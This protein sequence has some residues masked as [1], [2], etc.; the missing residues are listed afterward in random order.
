MSTGSLPPPPF[1]MQG[2]LPGGMIPRKS[3]LPLAILALSHVSSHP[4]FLLPTRSLANN[5]TAPAGR[6]APMPNLPN[7]LPF[8]P[9][10]GLPFPPPGG[11][12]NLPG[13]MAFP[14]PGAGGMP[15]MPLNFQIPGPAGSPPVGGPGAPP[16]GGFQG[17]PSGQFQGPNPYS[18][19]R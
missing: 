3:L 7:G 8:P 2:P 11:L 16:P 19:R 18:D 13:G 15:P 4:P 17:P 14:P 5:R 9:P 12:P 1:G 6:G 10:G